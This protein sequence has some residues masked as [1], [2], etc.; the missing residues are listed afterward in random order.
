MSTSPLPDH[1]GPSSAEEAEAYDQWFRT[2]V[3]KSLDDPRLGIPHEMVMAE[4]LTII[5]AAMEAGRE[6]SDS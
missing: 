3:Q 6:A 2:K 1:E 5:E 4:A